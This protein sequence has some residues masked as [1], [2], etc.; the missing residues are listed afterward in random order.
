MKYIVSLGLTV[1]CFCQKGNESNNFREVLSIGNSKGVAFIEVGEI[2]TDRQ[3]FIYVTD[4]YGYKVKK[5]SADG[6]CRGEFGSRGKQTGQFQAGPY[7]IDCMSDTLAV[8]DLG[9]ST[10]QFFTADM[11]SAGEMH[12]S[13]PI[14]DIA[15]NTHGQLFVSTANLYKQ[16]EE[17][18]MLYDRTGAVVSKVTLN[19]LSGAAAMDMILICTTPDDHLV[20]AFVN[21]NKIILYDSTLRVVSECKIA[22]LPDQSASN[23]PKVEG[24]GSIPE[25]EIFRDIGATKDGKIFLLGGF[26]SPHPNRDVYILDRNL[27]QLSTMVLPGETGLLYIDKNGAIFTREKKRTVVKKYLLKNSSF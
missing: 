5:F 8:V 3:G 18:L 9:T 14:V 2:V 16:N 21:R 7:K 17:V 13:S 23:A 20:V 15:F 27:N 25:G 10:V 26:Y 1:S 12:T 4:A 11:K 6:K 19:S 22:G 24:F